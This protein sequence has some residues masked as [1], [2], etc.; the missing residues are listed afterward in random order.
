MGM[1]AS[2][3]RVLTS[4]ADHLSRDDPALASLLKGFGLPQLTVSL[5]RR[6]VGHGAVVVVLFALAPLLFAIGLTAA[7]PACVLAGCVLC[8]IM[9]C[10]A[11]LW[12]TRFWLGGG[13]AFGW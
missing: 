10:L 2:E 8:V 7:I 5:W 9:P 1:T 4:I 13:A 6:I 12:S 11:V 3:R